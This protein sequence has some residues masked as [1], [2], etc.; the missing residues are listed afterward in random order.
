M[1]SLLTPELSNF[2]VANLRNSSLLRAIC[3]LNLNNSGA[4][5]FVQNQPG[6]P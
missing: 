1:N 3:A 6:V 2:F 5:C 4:S